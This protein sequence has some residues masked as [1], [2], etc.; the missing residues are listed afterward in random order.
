MLESWSLYNGTISVKFLSPIT[1]PAA[2]VAIFLNK[3]SNFKA[4]LI[5]FS[6]VGSS[7]CASCS[8]GS[9]ATDSASVKGL[10]GSKGII[11]DN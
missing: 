8:L 2:W 3:P 5:S 9:M 10:D 11:L 4:K 7:F 6:I 1:I